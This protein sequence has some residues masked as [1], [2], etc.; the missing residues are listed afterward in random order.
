MQSRFAILTSTCLGLLLATTVL[1]CGPGTIAAPIDPAP[2]VTPPADPPA[3]PK[4]GEQGGSDGSE[5]FDFPVRLLAQSFE[6]GGSVASVDATWS[7]Y[8]GE[9][10]WSNP[11]Q[12]GE[13]APD[14][15]IEVLV[16]VHGANK[17][18]SAYIELGF[19]N[20]RLS[21]NYAAPGEVLGV[22]VVGS[23]PNIGPI[24]QSSP[25]PLLFA[26]LMLRPQ[27]QP[28]FSG[29]GVV[30]KFYFEAGEIGSTPLTQSTAPMMPDC[31]A[32]LA[33]DAAGLLSWGY[34]LPG[35]FNQDGLVDLFDW[36]ALTVNYGDAVASLD[37]IGGVIHN[38]ATGSVFM[39]DISLWGMHFGNAVD[40]YNVYTGSAAD[41]PAGGTLLGSVPLTAA[42]G[43]PAVER[44]SFS[45]QVTSPQPS[46]HYWVKPFYGASEGTASN[47]ASN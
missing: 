28:G 2:I 15:L 26:A 7:H 13:V 37:S 5:Q 41:Y 42:V 25:T 27:D 40:G 30:A 24:G 18:K 44:L 46:S 34:Q 11:V 35:D 32:M 4:P 20:T 29:D 43:D 1:S 47:A 16:N 45:Y 19:D 38:S 22:E 9:M 31:A 6:L 17:L 14:D 21:P 10:W 39:G 23:I 8:E 3:N 12:Q 33:V 36:T